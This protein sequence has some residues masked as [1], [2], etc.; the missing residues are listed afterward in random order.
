MELKIYDPIRELFLKS[1]IL[2]IIEGCYYCR[3]YK[4]FIGRI[5]INLPVNKRI[6]L[7]DCSDYHDN[8]IRTDKRIELFM[9]YY[10]GS[11]PTLFIDGGIIR[12][13][14][15]VEELKAW[16]KGRLKDEFL[17]YENMDV[18]VFDKM[19][20]LTFDKYCIYKIEGGKKVLRCFG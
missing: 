16:L 11:Y 17:T 13:A 19:E 12:G 7:I 8:K 1:R 18:E 6:E 5:N 14:N 4:S 9:K 15:S 10:E 20:S 2:F 3:M